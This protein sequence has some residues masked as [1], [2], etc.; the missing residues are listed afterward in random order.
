MSDKASGNGE[1]REPG[2]PDLES[3]KAGP[4]GEELPLDPGSGDQLDPVDRWWDDGEVEE[5]AEHPAN[6]KLDPGEKKDPGAE[7]DREASPEEA[8][9]AAASEQE[10]DPDEKASPGVGTVR[11][12]RLGEQDEEGED[13][14]AEPAG[15]Q[16]AAG[17]E[18]PAEEERAKQPEGEKDR[19][20]ADPEE[21]PAKEEPARRPKPVKMEQP[22]KKAAADAGANRETSGKAPVPRKATVAKKEAAGG[23]SESILPAVKPSSVRKVSP[24]DWKSDKEKDAPAEPVD[25]EPETPAPAKPAKPASR[26]SAPAK[27]EKGESAAAA[28]KAA[29]E[30]EEGKKAEPKVVEDSKTDEKPEKKEEPEKKEAAKKEEAKKKEE[31]EKEARPATLPSVKPPK[32]TTAKEEKKAAKE[33][34]PK[35]KTGCWTIFATLFFIGSLL[36]VLLLA[37]AG[38]Y[39]WTQL[40]T[41]REDLE[42]QA[43]GRLEEKGIYLDYASW[44]YEFPRGLVFEDVS[45]FEDEQR[46]KAIFDATD[47]GVMVDL[48]QLVRQKGSVENAEVSFSDSSV[49]IYHGGE[50][51]GK[52]EGIDAEILVG[53]DGI[54]V[55]RFES[56]LFGLDVRASGRVAQ[57]GKRSGDGGGK[58]GG[59]KSGEASPTLPIDPELVEKLGSWI[60]VEAGDSRP[61]LEVEFDIDPKQPDQA[62][63]SGR[64][65]GKDFTWRGVKLASAAVAAEYDPE[66]KIVSIPSFQVGYGEGFLG[67]VGRIEAGSK[68]LTIAELQ[69]SVD[70]IALVSEFDPGF[71]EKFGSVRMADAPSIQAKGTVPLEVPVNANLEISYDQRQGIAILAGERELAISDIRGNF[72]F[73]GGTLETNDLAGKLLGGFAEVNG[74]VRVDA[75]GSP[76]SG[77]IEISR[78]PMAEIAEYFGKADLGMTGD[79]YLDFRGVGYTDATRIRG[80]G[81]LKIEGASL[82]SFPVIGPVQELLGSLVPVFGIQ[83][84]GSVTGAYIIESGIL[85][86]SD[87]TVR[88]GGAN[89]VTNGS[90]NL[91]TQETRFTSTASFEPTLAAATGLE[92]KTITVRGFGPISEPGLT[93]E[94]FPVDFVSSRVS[95]VLGTSPKTIEQLREIIGEEGDP[96]EVLGTKLD[97]LEAETGIDLGEEVQGLLKGLLEGLPAPEEAPSPPPLRAS[98]VTEEN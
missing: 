54:R 44:R 21:P 36:L 31:P 59:P 76:F 97:E 27:A 55:E 37:G 95:E 14:G 98:P 42:A 16:E 71:G 43:R 64:F 3:E 96:A 24:T 86:T 25:E 5:E 7:P 9:D 23:G 45:L 58:G 79:L 13:D 80:G 1:S 2:S 8:G 74:A 22:A 38:Y 53:S 72:T 90:L 20:K 75:E 35:K 15:K 77:L 92:G 82:P 6:R 57:T 60:A 4:E 50:L 40:P 89:L 62:K 84:D 33:A 12:L 68:V 11:V 70:A 69:S 51:L 32:E 91:S 48:E 26:K 66:A 61:L 83:G 30:Q 39:A 28:K 34:A 49:T 81:N 85:M 93:L 88:Q 46:E 67:G 65:S 10:P 78:M 73:N 19:P 94:D 17:G 56:R 87:L 52:L 63:L 47:I 29:A 18:P 41:L